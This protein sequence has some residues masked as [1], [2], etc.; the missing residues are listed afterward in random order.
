MNKKT[1][2]AL[3]GSIKKWEGI[4]A[5]TVADLGADNCPLC[6]MFL[7]SDCKGCPVYE[8]TGRD[9][10]E[11]TPYQKKW[12]PVAWRRQIRPTATTKEEKSAARAMLCFLKRLAV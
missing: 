9:S 12:V 7:G 3:E 6:K 4:A 5:G 11:G 1:R 10:C 8:K 2:K